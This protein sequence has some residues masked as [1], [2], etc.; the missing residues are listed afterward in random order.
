MASRWKTYPLALRGGLVTNYSP[1]QQGIMEPGSA[2]QLTNFE[3]SVEGGYRRI[4]GYEKFN[5]GYVPPYGEP[6]VQ[7]GSQSGTSILIADIHTEPTT[8][9]TITIAGVTG[10]YTISAVSYNSTNKTATLTLGSALASSPADQA[11]VTFAN[12]SDLI[13]G[14]AYFEGKTI[15]SRNKDFWEGSEGGSTWTRISVPSYGDVLVNGGGQSG[16]SLAV[17][18]LTLT[19]GV[20][21][22]FTI[23]G[24]NLCYTITAVGTVTAGACTLTIAPALDSTPSDN[25]VITFKSVG[26]SAPTGKVRFAQHD[27]TGTATLVAV[28]SVN[29]PVKYAG[30]AFTTMNDATS[31]VQSAAFVADFK[32]HMFYA[33][34]NTLAFSVP[35][36]DDNFDSGSGAGVIS[37][38]HDITG[39]IV[40]REQLIIFSTNTIYKLTGSSSSDF[41]LDPVTQNVGCSQP[42]TIR[43]VGGDIAFVYIDGVRLLTA[44]ERIGDFG[45]A[46]IS[47]N[48]Q[49]LMT[50][51]LTD[52]TSFSS[53]V[54]RKKNQYRIFGY[55]AAIQASAAEGFI[56]TQFADQTSEGI[57][58][59]QTEGIKVYV[60]DSV[61]SEP[62]A[63]E[64]IVFA[65]NTGYVYKMESGNDFDGTTINA[66]FYTPYLSFDDP[67]MRKSFYRVTTHM[68]TTGEVVGTLAFRLD[69]DE[70]GGIQPT[71]RQ[72]SNAG[73]GGGSTYGNAVYDSSYFGDKLISIFPVT[74]T[75]SGYTY[76]LLYTFS[77]ADQTPFS[78]DTILIEYMLHDRN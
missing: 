46:V 9:D 51:F 57:A 65:Y 71:S 17:D 58:W 47:R 6:V 43:E 3:P 48:V 21:D 19:P 73:S 74:V 28:D 67:V 24:V 35:F 53:L 70:P 13:N 14:I 4:L 8:S 64:V 49:D 7:G 38:P 25:A 32:Q 63:D 16:T 76:S 12:N 1:L 36:D 41:V 72:L 37:F 68:D 11:A 66:S 31:D 55:S 2:R 52:N 39:I 62:D 15:V 33:K 22:T 10:T 56:G 77:E 26:R 18:G 61:Y 42:D 29:F 69:Q 27:Y 50:Q 59:A 30:G 54:V 20:G 40:F 34:G 75:G 78:L 5:T 23:A 60:S 45:L 44:T